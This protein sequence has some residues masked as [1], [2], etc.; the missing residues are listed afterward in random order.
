M[1]KLLT[2][3]GMVFLLLLTSCG[4]TS[5]DARSSPDPS[6][7]NTFLEDGGAPSD[8]TVSP[9]DAQDSSESADGG[10]RTYV[11]DVPNDASIKHMESAWKWKEFSGSETHF[12]D[13]N[14]AGDLKTALF[15]GKTYG[16][17]YESSDR[18]SGAQGCLT[19]CYGDRENGVKLYFSAEDGR[20]VGIF[21]ER[22]SEV[23][24]PKPDA[25]KDWES[26]LPVA[27]TLASRY[28]PIAESRI[29]RQ[30]DADYETESGRIPLYTYVWRRYLGDFPT[31]E[32]ITVSLT[33]KGDIKSLEAPTAGLFDDRAPVSVDR[34]ALAASV[35]GMM[36]LLYAEYYDDYSYSA[37]RES[38][39]FTAGGAPIVVSEMEVTLSGGSGVMN[40]R[41][42]LLTT[43]G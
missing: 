3:I 17:T 5:G 15:E 42:L 36:K 18:A 7:G 33:S 19:D 13:P 26:G 2:C 41:V 20:F 6:S 9:G 34:E 11:M 38:L 14:K 32:K 12:A 30:P 22:G 24:S 27:E 28:F 40:S 10:Y 21:F 23:D 8:V 37:S 35:D 1:K 43:V 39:S 29:E 16:G 25:I 4:N 31:E